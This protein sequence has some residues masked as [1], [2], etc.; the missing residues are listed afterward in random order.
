MTSLSVHNFLVLYKF[1]GGD[2]MCYNLKFDYVIKTTQKKRIAEGT[3]TPLDCLL[4]TLI[5]LRRG[6]AL[7]DIAMMFGV[8]CSF[9]SKVFYTYIQLLYLQFVRL[10]EKIFTPR[11]AQPKSS[12]PRCLKPFTNYRV[13]L[14]VTSIKIQAP[15]HYRQQGNTWS[16]YKS[17]N[18][19]NYMVGCNKSGGTSFVS[20]GFEGAISDIELFAKSGIIDM[21]HPNDVILGD[22]GFTVQHLC[23][24]VGAK[25]IYPPF[26]GDRERLS[27]EEEL[28]TK[29]IAAGRVHVE[30]LIRKIKCFLLLKR[31]TNRMIPILDQCFYV[32]AC[33]VNF[34]GPNVQ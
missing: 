22:R 33:L 20:R 27:A 19:V 5:R 21:L 24:L 7:E 3:L 15:Y 13:T 11:G 25:V 1:I 14:D 23:D 12:L 31:I 28:L 9:A 26:L 4:M 17:E 16:S 18:C 6:F 8:S 34:D 32:A 2:E 30:R 10:R 29:K